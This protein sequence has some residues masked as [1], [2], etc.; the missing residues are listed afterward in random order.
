LPKSLQ[1]EVLA[2]SIYI[3]NSLKVVKALQYKSSAIFIKD[4]RTS[5]VS[6]PIFTSN[7][8]GIW[9]AAVQNATSFL[10]ALM[11]H[12]CFVLVDVVR[13]AID[14]RGTLDR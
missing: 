5:M 13:S 14:A 12:R 8:Y 6:Q 2:F 4:S 10:T 7:I 3:V 11:I 9:T 1:K